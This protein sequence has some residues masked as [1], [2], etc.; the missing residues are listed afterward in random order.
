M[1][2]NWLQHGIGN[3]FKSALDFVFSPSSLASSIELGRGDSDTDITYIMLKNANG[4]SVYFYP[5]SS[6]DALTVSTSKP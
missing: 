1:L 6:A 3:K 4:T 2:K 5:N